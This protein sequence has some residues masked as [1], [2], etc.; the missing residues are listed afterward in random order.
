MAA[1]LTAWSFAGIIGPMLISYLKRVSAI[2]IGIPPDQAYN[3]SFKILSLT[4]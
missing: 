4:Y 3:S 2:A 1:L